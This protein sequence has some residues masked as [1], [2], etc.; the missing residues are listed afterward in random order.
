MANILITGGKEIIEFFN[1]EEEFIC[2]I[3]HSSSIS[4]DETK[5]LNGINF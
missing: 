1:K 2:N 3:C 5:K 4:V